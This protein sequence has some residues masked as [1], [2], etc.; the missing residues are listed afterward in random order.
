MALEVQGAQH[1][2]HSTSWYKNVKKLEDIVNCDRQKRCICQDNGIFLLEVWYDEKPEIIIPERIQKIKETEINRIGFSLNE[3]DT[4]RKY[5]TENVEKIN[6]V[7]SFLPD[8]A[9]DYEKRGYLKSLI[10]TP[11]THRP[12]SVENLTLDLGQLNLSGGT[13]DTST[14]FSNLF[15]GLVRTMEENSKQIGLL[16]QIEQARNRGPVLGE[17]EIGGSVTCANVYKNTIFEN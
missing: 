16:I 15:S 6:V 17:F 2:L 4:L 7:V 8:Y 9:T 5:F 1:R 10:S 14:T 11:A 3:Q 12:T 13:S